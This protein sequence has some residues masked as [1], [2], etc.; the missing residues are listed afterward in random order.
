MG[1]DKEYSTRK[2]IESDV[3][4]E[5]MKEFVEKIEWYEREI[6][7]QEVKSLEPFEKEKKKIQD[8]FVNNKRPIAVW[9]RWDNALLIWGSVHTPFLCSSK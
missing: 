1:K 9:P 5:K 7:I 3:D 4:L 6:K 2:D 8:T